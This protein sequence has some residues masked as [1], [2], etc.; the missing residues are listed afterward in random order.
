MTESMEVLPVTPPSAL[1]LLD[2]MSDDGALARI[3][4][5]YPSVPVIGVIDTSVE[6]PEA[7]A[8]LIG[9]SV[10]EL[11]DV[12]TET[13]PALLV[14]LLANATA[15]PLIRRIERSLPRYVSAQARVLVRAA[16]KVAVS[17]GGAA[18]L[19]AYLEVSQATVTVWC[20]RSGLPKP[21]RLQAWLRLL[22][23]A[24]LLT[25]KG[26]TIATVARACGYSSDRALRRAMN[27]FVGADTR[28]VSQ[29]D[30]FEEVMRKF[31]DELSE[32]RDR[33]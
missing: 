25:D 28:T 5:E 19:A 9:S 23:A 21:R 22:L 10:S 27:E 16:A 17:S 31:L 2:Q 30:A 11:I 13:H 3:F 29:D 32:C 12:S 14:E 24:L 8:A 33:M 20:Q 1:V 18:E 6:A 26:R 15:R 7:V 4:A